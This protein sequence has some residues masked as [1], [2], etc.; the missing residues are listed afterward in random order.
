MKLSWKPFV[1]VPL[2]LAENVVFGMVPSLRPWVE[3]HL[4]NPY[5]FNEAH[6]EYSRR[7]FD[8]FRTALPAD[9][10]LAGKTVLELGPGGSVG[11]GLLAL[12]AGAARYLAID[13]GE[14]TFVRPRQIRGY[15]KLVG[16]DTV[17]RCFEKRAGRIVYK[18]EAIQFKNITQASGYPL[19]DASVD[20]IYSC[21]VLEHVHDLERAFSEMARVLK[22]GGIM[23]H[24]VDLR[25]H[26][27]SQD[28]L[29]FLSIPERVFRALFRHTGGYVNR[30]RV[31]RYREFCGRH[32]IGIVSLIPVI[33]FQDQATPVL[34]ARY[35][36][37]DIQILSFVLVARKTY[38]HP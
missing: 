10:S 32:G 23:Y 14:H 8:E 4:F 9:V 27:F 12:Q 30:E 1:K 15:R 26:I 19:P 21:A 37:E 31:S 16:N 36:E 11:F 35:S 29:W 18:E 7:K 3:R 13:N 5:D 24:E 33:Q 34:E 2:V 38:E 6:I 17:L 28:S 25:D 20:V 22:P